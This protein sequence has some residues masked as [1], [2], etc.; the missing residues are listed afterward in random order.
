MATIDLGEGRRLAYWE[1]GTGPALVFIHGVGTSGDIWR[2]DLADLADTSRTIVYDRR[3]YG[4]SSPSPRD[5]SAHTDDAIALVEA[6]GAAP[7][8]IVGYSGGSIVALDLVQRR[9]ELARAVVLVDPA[10]NVKRSATPG[11]VRALATARLLRR[12]RGDKR[13][14]EHWMRYVAGYSTGGSAWD[15]APVERRE[16][17]LHNASA[18]FDDFA[19]GGGKHVDE[20][21]LAGIEIPVTIIEAKLSP[22]VLRRSCARLA[23]LMPQARMVT[24]ADSGHHIALD[25]RDELL[26]VL[27]E[28][29]SAPSASAA[30]Q[31]L[32]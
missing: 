21:R 14:A 19:S 7:A 18:I 8:V 1:S 20:S 27:R 31:P 25:A 29:T 9:P 23:R 17:L 5:W 24:L 4:D 11:A 3:G 13:G 30:A 2:D 26:D 16:K 10:F 15:T 12:L 32:S 6:L 22:P 28:A